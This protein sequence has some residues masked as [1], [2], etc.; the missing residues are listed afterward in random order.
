[1]SILNLLAALLPSATL[2]MSNPPADSPDYTTIPPDPYQ[3]EQ[4]LSAARINAQEAV[5]QAEEKTG[6]TVRGVTAKFSGDNLEY[7][8]TLVHNGVT[9]KVIVDGATGVVTAPML[10]IPNAIRTALET[11]DGLVK[12]VFENTDADPPTITVVIYNEGKRHDVIVNAVSGK[13]ISDTVVPRF[14]GDAVGDREMISTESGLMYVELE[15][16]AGEIPPDASSKV[17]VHYTGWLV[18]G[19]KFDSSVDR[20]EPAVFPLNGVIKGWTEGVGGMKV[21]GKRK[22][23]IPFGLAYGPAG[24]GQIPAKATLIFDVQLLGIEE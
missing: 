14:P 24:R 21:G 23:I 11:S 22:L 12:A 15:E 4:R 5:K 1:M 7:E 6:G 2:L 9:R 17:S 19:T 20:G 13:M 3:V 18:D 16:G 10:T 8:L